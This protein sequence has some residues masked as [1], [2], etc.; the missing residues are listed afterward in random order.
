M[1]VFF[2]LFVSQ[3]YARSFL[4]ALIVLVCLFIT[5]VCCD[6]FVYPNFMRCYTLSVRFSYAVCN[7]KYKSIFVECASVSFR[8]VS[9]CRFAVFCVDTV[10][11]G[12]FAIFRFHFFH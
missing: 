7:V 5:P 8:S 12:E 3:D 1:I 6:V 4:L 11:H 10:F 9:W 2:P